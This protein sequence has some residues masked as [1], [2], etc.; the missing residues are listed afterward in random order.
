MIFYNIVVTTLCSLTFYFSARSLKSFL[1]AVSRLVA[2]SKE[3]W[4]SERKGHL[5][6]NEISHRK[7]DNEEKKIIFFC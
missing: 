2:R 5:I 3:V 6:A 1:F 7:K 4:K